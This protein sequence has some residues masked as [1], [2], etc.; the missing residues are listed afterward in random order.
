VKI[1]DAAQFLGVKVSWIYEQV[2]LDRMPSH[3][4]GHFRRFKLSELDAW[5]RARQTDGA[6]QQN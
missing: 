6:G 1:E 2:R 4:V 3:K 5:A